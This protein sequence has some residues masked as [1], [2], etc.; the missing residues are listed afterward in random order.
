MTMV[1]YSI[2]IFNKYVLMLLI[3]DSN[4]TLTVEISVPIVSIVIIVAFGLI[5]LY[6]YKR[7]INKFTLKVIIIILNNYIICLPLL[8]NRR[9]IIQIVKAT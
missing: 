2:S 8:L 1:I 7:H 5:S 4:N 9:T 3:D 6:L